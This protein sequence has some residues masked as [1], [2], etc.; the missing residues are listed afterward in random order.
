MADLTDLFR[1]LVVVFLAMHGLGHFVWF[2]AAWTRVRAG[3]GDGRWGLPGNVSVRSPLG[4]VWG[5]LALLAVV[6]FMWAS[7]ALLA[8][9]PGWRGLTFLGIVVS[10]V[11]VGPWRRASPGSTWLVAI[12]ADLVLLI[13]LALPLSV[14][15]VAA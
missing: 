7:L 13:L 5:V 3:V 10:F 6:L 14:E 2:L 1:L 12:L 4:K 15:L 11:A 9:S 8:G